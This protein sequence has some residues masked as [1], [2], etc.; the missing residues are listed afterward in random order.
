ML[1]G[2]GFGQQH[3]RDAGGHDQSAEAYD[4]RT[5]V[6]SLVG[7][8][9]GDVTVGAAVDGRA[10][11]ATLCAPDALGRRVESASTW[12]HNKAIA[13]HAATPV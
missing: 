7:S 4:T 6:L 3:E 8:V 11:A 1:S 10:E 5:G 9:V 2:S 13:K 12:S